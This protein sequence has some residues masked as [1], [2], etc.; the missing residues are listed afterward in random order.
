MNLWGELAAGTGLIAS[1]VTLLD[2]ALRRRRQGLIPASTLLAEPSPSAHAQA[3]STDFWTESVPGYGKI[4]WADNAKP[5]YRAEFAVVFIHGYWSNCEGAWGKLP[6]WILDRAG[7]DVDVVTYQYPSAPWQRADVREAARGLFTLL[8]QRFAEH[9]H[10]VFVTHS[11]GGL[12]VKQLL[13]MESSRVLERA[14]TRDVSYQG[15]NSLAARVLRVY[16]IAVPHDGG[17]LAITAPGVLLSA[18][19]APILA[20]TS[21]VTQGRSGMGNNL[22]TWQLLWRNPWIRRLERRYI[23]YLR[24][25][26][27]LHVPR[28]VAVEINAE[29]DETISRVDMNARTDAEHMAVRGSHTAAKLPTQPND[30]IVHMLASRLAKLLDPLP[31]RLASHTVSRV[32]NLEH[33]PPYVSRLTGSVVPRNRGV[34]PPIRT[35]QS[36]SGSQMEVFE[37]L[38]DILAQLSEAPS[39]LLVTGDAGVGKSVVLRYL[40]R[41]MALKYLRTCLEEPSALPVFFPLQQSNLEIGSDAVSNATESDELWCKLVYDYAGFVN[42]NLSADSRSNTLAAGMAR[43]TREW[44]ES[45]LKDIPTVLIF[46]GVDELLTNT[47]GLGIGHVKSMVTGLRARYSSNGSLL[48]ILGVRNSQ[49]SIEILAATRL[50]IDKLTVEQADSAFPGAA[51]WLTKIPY[52]ELRDLLLT[53]LLLYYVG[54]YIRAIEPT[55]LATKSALLDYALDALVAREN[56][57]RYGPEWKDALAVIGWVYYSRSLGEAS[58]EEL[59]ST[60]RDIGS[61]WHEALAQDLR[62]TTR[63][64]LSGFASASDKEQCELLLRRTVF[65]PTAPTRYRFRH[66]EWEDYLASRFLAACIRTGY[67]DN[68]GDVPCLTSMFRLAGEQLN[69]MVIGASDIHNVFVRARETGRELI[70]GNYGATLFNSLVPFEPAAV[71]RLLEET[72]EL[73]GIYRHILLTG[74]GYRTLKAHPADQSRHMFLTHVGTAFESLPAMQGIPAVT[75]SAAWCYLKAFHDKFGRQVP[76]GSWIGIDALTQDLAQAA[77]MMCTLTDDGPQITPEQRS[78]QIA[79]LRVQ[80]SVLLDPDRPVSVVHYLYYLFAVWK[81]NGQILEVEHSLRTIFE[82]GGAIQLAYERVDAVPELR[83]LFSYMQREFNAVR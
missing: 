64:L 80:E 17:R 76:S 61:R 21:L 8:T 44:L 69:G 50:A 24:S 66:R 46:D 58:V 26:E 20:A 79:F 3:P 72:L 62:E 37:G 10:L 27:A 22:I 42:R 52:P 35:P 71:C 55:A 51:A 39:S 23:D 12:V 25:L 47:P 11:T 16:N 54:P 45:R 75:Q 15:L 28:P 18:L 70:A 31:I 60:A 1:V 29:N 40:G 30:I 13:V 7:L 5:G 41:H 63:R 4:H 32:Y 38:V 77:Q 6:Q 81:R 33:A 59:C 36:V 2:F 68:L 74:L 78:L 82:P 9:R 65:Q 83:T 49:P 19:L 14:N 57:A 56:E 73:A 53:P 43:F 48:V 67:V 34:S